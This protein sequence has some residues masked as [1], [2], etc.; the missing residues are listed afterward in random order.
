MLTSPSI[1]T[2][3][4]YPLSLCDFVSS[5]D[6]NN[7]WSQPN[8]FAK[9]APG[10]GWECKNLP[11]GKVHLFDTD[12]ALDLYSH[13]GSRN[14]RDL[15]VMS[16]AL[17]IRNLA[18]TAMKRAGIGKKRMRELGP[19]VFNAGL[20]AATDCLDPVAGAPIDFGLF[21]IEPAG[22]DMEGDP[23]WPD[24]SAGLMRE[25][26][27]K[28]ASAGIMRELRHHHPK[29]SGLPLDSGFIIPESHDPDPAV[30]SEA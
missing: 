9:P 16:C 18:Y 1:L 7:P 4:C 6:V 23:W 25:F 13:T 21:D 2:D 5:I 15:L 8:V 11:D 22:Y 12:R 19:D 26:V 20:T 30:E 29:R 27:K 10:F 14:A 17:M 3:G 24:T 28:A